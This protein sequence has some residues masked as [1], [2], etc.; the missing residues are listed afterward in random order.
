MVKVIHEKHNCINCGA[1]LGS[2]EFTMNDMGVDL[3][4]VKYEKNEEEK[5]NIGKKEVEKTPQ[6]EEAITI[7]PVQCIK[8]EE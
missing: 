3:V 8:L 1:C 7:C 5:T 4:E 2:S 6:L